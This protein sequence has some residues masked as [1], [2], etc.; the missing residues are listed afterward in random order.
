MPGDFLLVDSNADRLIME[1]CFRLCAIENQTSNSVTHRLQVSPAHLGL[2]A[3]ELAKSL[4]CI[5]GD[6]VVRFVTRRDL[7][8]LRNILW[9]QRIHLVIPINPLGALLHGHERAAN[10]RRVEVRPVVSHDLPGQPFESYE[11]TL[12][13]DRIMG[14]QRV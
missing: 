3:A 5:L 10:R 8:L 13:R 14:R 11:L 4:A 6:L 12:R 1:L 7:L 2:V 9:T